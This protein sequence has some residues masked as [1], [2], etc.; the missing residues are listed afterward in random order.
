MNISDEPLSC[1]R[2]SLSFGSRR[3][4]MHN[5]FDCIYIIR[6]SV[7]SCLSKITNTRTKAQSVQDCLS[8]RVCK[9]VKIHETRSESDY[10]F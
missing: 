8:R 1:S 10:N 6:T 5:K 9:V 2:F 3:E 7:I 4:F